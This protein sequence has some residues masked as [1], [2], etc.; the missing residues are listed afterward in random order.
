MSTLNCYK[1]SCGNESGTGF[2]FDRYQPNYIMTAKH[3]IA[4]ALAESPQPIF[5]LVGSEKHEFQIIKSNDL[6]LDKGTV[7]ILEPKGNFL[8]PKCPDLYVF[9]RDIPDS[10]TMSADGFRENEISRKSYSLHH[11]RKRDSVDFSF[12]N[13]SKQV[14]SERAN[15]HLDSH[16][17]ECYRGLSGAP[18]VIETVPADS[19]DTSKVKKVK[20]LVGIA[21]CQEPSATT[22]I[23]AFCGQDFYEEVYASGI[24]LH[25]EYREDM[26]VILLGDIDAVDPNHFRACLQEMEKKYHGLVHAY[27]TL[28]KG[29]DLSVVDGVLKPSYTILNKAKKNDIYQNEHGKEARTHLAELFKTTLENMQKE[30][31]APQ[32]SQDFYNQLAFVASDFAFALEDDETFHFLR[33]DQ[34]HPKS[35]DDFNWQIFRAWRRCHHAIPWEEALGCAIRE[36]ESAY[37]YKTETDRRQAVRNVL[38]LTYVTLWTKL[39]S[40]EDG[41]NPQSLRKAIAFL[42]STPKAYHSPQLYLSLSRLY[43]EQKEFATAECHAIAAHTNCTANQPKCKAVACTWLGHARVALRK[44]D[45]V[46][47]Y[48]EAGQYYGSKFTLFPTELALFRDNLKFL[49][50]LETNNGNFLFAIEYTKKLLACSQGCAEAE[51]AYER[52]CACCFAA[53]AHGEIYEIDI[54]NCLNYASEIAADAAHKMA[55]GVM[56]NYVSFIRQETTSPMRANMLMQAYN[57]GHSVCNIPAFECYRIL[58]QNILLDDLRKLSPGKYNSLSGYLHDYFCTLGYGDIREESFG[59]ETRLTIPLPDDAHWMICTWPSSKG[60]GQEH[61]ENAAKYC[62]EHQ[63]P[64]LFCILYIE[65]NGSEET[66][67][68]KKLSDIFMDGNKDV[69]SDLTLPEATSSLIS[70]YIHPSHTADITIFH[71]LLNENRLA[72]SPQPVG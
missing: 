28:C 10:C 13:Q 48:F 35:W 60:S 20:E 23:G 50:D 69:V 65:K 67:Y 47:S 6:T 31:P 19:A 59:S 58:A 55:C 70:G 26:V 11:C 56:Q 46:A 4:G 24:S 49:V 34:H 36:L 16:T 7:A 64:T 72:S 71:L 57:L 32:T 44:T 38:P 17:S 62:R 39:F 43:Y 21:V 9:T 29:N 40:P 3:V 54:K 51:E 41:V 8:L 1:I 30:L 2:Q 5:V 68:I 61:F 12:K 27:D 25:K 14:I 33:A 52:Y 18:V 63:I 22:Y 53:A 66:Q 42:E 37:S 45:A 15:Y